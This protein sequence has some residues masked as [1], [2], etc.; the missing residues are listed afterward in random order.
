MRVILF[1]QI[2]SRIYFEGGLPYSFM[3]L[4]TLQ[5][6]VDCLN[7]AVI[8]GLACLFKTSRILY[9]LSIY[10]WHRVLVNDSTVSFGNT[11]LSTLVLLFLSF[12]SPL[13]IHF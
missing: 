4:K 9:T 12:G 2:L 11:S 6:F 5:I 3:E 8:P 10:I 1:L 7:K 13:L